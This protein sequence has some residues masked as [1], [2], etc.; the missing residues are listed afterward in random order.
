MRGGEEEEEEEIIVR[1]LVCEREREREREPEARERGHK[2]ELGSYQYSPIEPKMM[3]FLFCFGSILYVPSVSIVTFSWTVY[4]AFFG[5]VSA[6]IFFPFLWE[7][8]LR[9]RLHRRKNLSVLHC[10]E[11]KYVVLLDFCTYIILDE[12]SIRAGQVSQ[13]VAVEQ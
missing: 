7:V 12:R 9:L 5:L 1:V 2:H 8:L 6:A 11:S 4:V 3:F 10:N 13:I